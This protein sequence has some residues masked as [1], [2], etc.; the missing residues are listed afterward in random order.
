MPTPA[1]LLLVLATSPVEVCAEC[2]PGTVRAELCAPHA[3]AERKG[4]KACRNAQRSKS[5]EYR[6]EALRELAALTEAHSNA[7]S[8]ALARALAEGLDSDFVAVRTETVAL[9]GQGQHPEVAL[10]ELAAAAHAWGERA[11]DML[12][13]QVELQVEQMRVLA[14]NLEGLTDPKEQRKQS[15]AA[16]ARERKQAEER[17]ARM[18]RLSVEQEQMRVY[19]EALAAGLGGF[20]DDRAAA[21]LTE[22]LQPEGPWADSL[23]AARGLARFGTLETTRTLVE[24]LGRCEQRLRD[25]RIKVRSGEA[26]GRVAEYLTRMVDTT[27]AYREY[28]HELLLTVSDD[29]SIDETP[30]LLPVVHA[31]WERWLE[32]HRERF[33]RELGQ[34]PLPWED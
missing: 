15:K 21:A 6:L 26:A 12:A 24:A 9:L 7:P 23:T 16:L 20:W 2:S 1:A 30:A 33:P 13:E 19:R 5:P 27:V 8:P 28:L 31:E 18:D 11:S 25:L 3:R 22:L 10:V 34:L 14:A 32:E 29:R 17:K 4:I